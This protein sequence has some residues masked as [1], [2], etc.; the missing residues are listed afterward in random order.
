MTSVTPSNPYVRYELRGRVRLLPQVQN[1]DDNQPAP[2]VAAVWANERGD[3]TS[4]AAAEAQAYE[5]R[6]SG[7]G[8]G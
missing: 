5:K 1:P 6:R 2:A 7:L 8:I 3:G 4:P